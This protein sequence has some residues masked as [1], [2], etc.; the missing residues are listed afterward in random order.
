MAKLLSIET[1]ILDP[2]FWF[3]QYL[4][5][6]RSDELKLTD[7]KARRMTSKPMCL[8]QL[9]SCYQLDDFDGPI[10]S[11]RPTSISMETNLARHSRQI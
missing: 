6:S 3:W 7:H 1:V 8:S 10:S 2:C 9:P 4:R 5:N 11:L